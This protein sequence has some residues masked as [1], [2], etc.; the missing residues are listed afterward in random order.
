MYV[1]FKYFD[2]KP[3]CG[4]KPHP[5]FNILFQ[6]GREGPD[7]S[8]SLISSTITENVIQFI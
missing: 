4:R 2:E 1:E 7:S 5:D 3:R 6:R 8:A